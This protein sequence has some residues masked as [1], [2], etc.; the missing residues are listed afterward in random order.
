MAT[1]NDVAREA[2][3]SPMT[4]S[5]VMN[6]SSAVKE[7]TKK[8]VLEAVN[9]LNYQPN[10]LARSLSADRMDSI[11]VV[12][13][14]MENPM[15]SLMVAGI[16]N[17]AAVYGYDVVI[18]CSHDLHSSMQSVQTLLSKRVSGLIVLPIEYRMEGEQNLPMMAGFEQEFSRRMQKYAKWDFPIVTIGQQL[19]E[20][21]CS[22]II[23]NY[24]DGAVS[25]VEYLAEQGHR[26][27]GFVSH[28]CFDKGIWKERYQGFEK[29][30]G[31]YGLETKKEW[32]V[33]SEE[34]VE[35]ARQ[36]VLRL[37]EQEELPTALY[38]ANDV[39]AAGTCLAVADKG[40]SVPG[41]ISV[42]GH[43]GRD[44]GE[45][46]RPALTTMA[47]EPMELGRQAVAAMFNLQK[48]QRKIDVIMRPRLLERASVKKL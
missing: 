17:E 33:F 7:E 10:L 36:A 32:T 21:A 47:I 9:K 39:L 38:C 5:R 42:I 31:K 45:M 41:D 18:A 48:T 29:A 11:G 2:G 44:F 46:L 35:G 24:E 19:P 26:K 3:V 1:L 43:D 8:R 34:T 27:I 37:L 6:G 30:I 12:V 22:R 25:A 28:S 13:T 23:E 16:Y 14:R 20:G 40:L 15:Y 4:V